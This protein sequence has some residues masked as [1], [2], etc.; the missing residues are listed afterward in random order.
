[1]KECKIG[2]LEK[3]KAMAIYQQIKLQQTIFHPYLL[4]VSDVSV[5]S[6]SHFNV[7]TEYCEQGDLGKFIKRQNQHLAQADVLK[8][9]A[10]IAMALEMMHVSHNVLH[11]KLQLE[12]VLI[13]KDGG[14]K[15]C[16]L[17]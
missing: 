13:C 2:S 16:S 1:M 15:I 12:H 4:Q 11:K 6:T 10:Q 14:I 8:I 7:I 17:G 9:F 5:V 3:E